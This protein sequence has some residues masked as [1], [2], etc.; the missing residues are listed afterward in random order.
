MAAIVSRFSRQVYDI[1]LHVNPIMLRLQL[2]LHGGFDDDGRGKALSI[3]E[4]IAV[5]LRRR[6]INVG[7]PGYGT[8]DPVMYTCPCPVNLLS[9]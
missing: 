9:V 1:Y 2:C 5:G 6:R 3:L 8:Q 4:R 7:S